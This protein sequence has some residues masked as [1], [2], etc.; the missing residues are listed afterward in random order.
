MPY[1][2]CSNRI[3]S[4][5]KHTVLVESVGRRVS[6]IEFWIK[7]AQ[8]CIALQNAASACTVLAALSSA[9]VSRL[10]ETWKAVSGTHTQAFL[11]AKRYIDPQSNHRT[12]RAFLR[13]ADGPCVPFI[14]E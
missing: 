2:A 5:V 8:R 11:L 3:V 10:N 6:A 9:D 13:D 1:S 14:G 12:M 4:L 7:V